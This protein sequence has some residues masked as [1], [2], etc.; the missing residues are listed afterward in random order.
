MHLRAIS[1]ADLIRNKVSQHKMDV[2]SQIL[3]DFPNRKFILVGDSGERDPEV[4]RQIYNRYPHQ[5]VKIFIHDVSSTRARSADE[6]DVNRTD[7]FYNMIRKCISR[8]QNGADYFRLHHSSTTTSAL[9]DAIGEADVPE[10]GKIVE[11]PGVPLKTKLDLFNDRIAAVSNGLPS[12]IFTL[13]SSAS[14]LLK[15]S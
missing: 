15:V 12:G 2:I 8:D 6:R 4:Y 3:E 10:P 9:M 14:Q 5:I 11:D 7:S 1:A 13:F